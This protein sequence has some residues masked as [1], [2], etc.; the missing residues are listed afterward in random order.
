MERNTPL[1]TQPWWSTHSFSSYGAGARLGNDGQAVKLA[2]R[3]LRFAKNV[4]FLSQLDLLFPHEK[5]FKDAD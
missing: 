1:A 5:F 2:E 4:E 3:L